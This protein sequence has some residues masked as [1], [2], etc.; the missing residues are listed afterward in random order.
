[1][2]IQGAELGEFGEFE[3]AE[4]EDGEFEG[5]EF[6]DGEF[7]DEFSGEFEDEGGQFLSE[8]LGTAAG[9]GEMEALSESEELE[10]ASELLEIDSDQ[11]LEQFLGNLVKSASRAVGGLI[12]SPVGRAL[13]GVLKKV[14]KRALPVVGGALGSMIAPGVGTA[15]GSKLGSM[16]SGMFEAEFE[17]MP[18]EAAEFEAARRFVNLAASAAQHAALA[19][20]R[21]GVSPQTV[22]RAAVATAAR[23]HAPGVHRTMMRSLGGPAAGTRRPA[24]PSTR[25]RA[26]PGRSY[27][28][29][30]LARYPAGRP[31]AG[32]PH[33]QRALGSASRAPAPGGHA[34]HHAY[35]LPASGRWVRRGRRIVILGV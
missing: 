16:A 1:M 33:P 23:T 20:P 13:G 29:G 24:G 19:R 15:I 8:I 5:A 25:R 26:M 32:R 9:G 12:K 10:L 7:E 18:P 21:P 31:Q 27:S 28:G 6:E 17:S 35:G 22:A 14:A 11:E 3:G 2:T 34:A 30:T 4:F